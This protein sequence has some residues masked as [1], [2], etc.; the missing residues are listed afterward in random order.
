MVYLI[1]LQVGRWMILAGS[2]LSEFLCA[3]DMIPSSLPPTHICLK[4]WCNF[5][6]HHNSRDSSELPF[7]VSREPE[8]VT[9]THP[10]LALRSMGNKRGLNK[11][12]WLLFSF[13]PVPYWELLGKMVLILEWK[14]V[15]WVTNPNL[16]FLKQTFRKAG[17][18]ITLCHKHHGNFV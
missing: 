12:A 10:I 13:L 8:G 9:L 16:D 3:Y 15:V 14:L 2:A 1:S 11:G 6:Y 4:I 18:G 7:M 17:W 5:E